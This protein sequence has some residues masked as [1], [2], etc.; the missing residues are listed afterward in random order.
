ML[1]GDYV[2]NLL[3]CDTALAVAA[4]AAS[5]AEVSAGWAPGDDTRL[6]ARVASAGAAVHTDT[7]HMYITS[8]RHLW[9]R[10]LDEFLLNSFFG[11]IL[12]KLFF[13]Y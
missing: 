9:T 5:M 12:G 13:L 4:N 10:G 2:T 8:A 11:D 6:R 1:D 3:D 7:R